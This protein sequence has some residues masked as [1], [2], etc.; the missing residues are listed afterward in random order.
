MSENICELC[1]KEFK[2]KSGYT[3]HKNR[4]TPCNDKD[5]KSKKYT[6]QEKHNIDIPKPIIKWVGGKSQIIDNLITQFPNEMNDYYEIFLG[7]GSVLIALLTY[8]NKG[9]IKLRGNVYAYDVNEHLIYVYKNIQ[10]YHNELYEMLQSVISELN[11]CNEDIVNIN[12]NPSTL[13]EAMLSKENYY[14]WIRNKYNKLSRNEKN[15]ILGSALFIFLN[16]TCFRGVFR[17]G[18]NGFNVPYGHYKNP[19]IINKEH[20]DT[21]HNLIQNVIFECKDYTLSMEKISDGSFVYLDPP[22]A[23]EKN[24][25]FVSYTENGFNIENHKNLFKLCNKLCSEN[26][27]FIMSN[28]DVELVRE[29]FDKDKYTIHSILC[30]R[31]I[32]SKN[33][34]K[35]AMEVVIKNF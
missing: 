27:K 22:Y 5:T 10:T 24:T 31:S 6:S 12:R 18:P 21:I 25:S 32:N 20:L 17:V 34:E 19:E 30:K 9:L 35:K 26:K 13:E 11:K 1:G 15:S 8:I 28:S 4:K 3:S 33:P 7:G 2:N 29:S 16:K 23:P 14:Y